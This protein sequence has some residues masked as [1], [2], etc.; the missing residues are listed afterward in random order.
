[1]IP[2]S[3]DVP[4]R[5]FPVVNVMLIAANFAVFLL[6]EL[7]NGD[8]AVNQASFYPCDVNNTC[9]LGLPWGV[10]WITAMFMHAG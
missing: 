6:Y 1:M 4:A 3:D 8:A 10:S 9:H 7:P 5:R 2:L